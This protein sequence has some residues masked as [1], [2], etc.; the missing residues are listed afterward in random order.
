MSAY[1]K[2]VI[3]HAFVAGYK[4]FEFQGLA[5]IFVIMIVCYG[6]LGLISCIALYI[7][8]LVLILVMILNS[9]ARF[10]EC[11]RQLASRV[12][13]LLHRKEAAK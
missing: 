3:R 12:K 7:Y 4:A 9:N 10:K 1:G 8:A 13:A 2:G 5:V 6:G 11:K